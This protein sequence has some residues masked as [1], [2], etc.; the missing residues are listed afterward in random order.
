MVYRKLIVVLLTL[1]FLV[2]MLG[3]TG[4]AKKPKP[5]AGG[6][7]TMTPEQMD[8]MR[9]GPGGS[10]PGAGPGP[11]P[12]VPPGPGGPPGS[13]APVTPPPPTGQ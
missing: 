11:A 13:S 2:A 5:E 6:A 1:V 3:L 12:A 7:G 9:G 10:A 4:C 8:Q